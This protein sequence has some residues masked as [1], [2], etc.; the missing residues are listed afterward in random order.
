MVSCV[1]GTPVSHQRACR[2][3]RGRG[4]D[5]SY[6]RALA[7]DAAPPPPD[8]P[9]SPLPSSSRDTTWLSAVLIVAAI[10]GAFGSALRTPFQYDD[11]STVVENVSIR[12]LSAI[13][14]VL[15]PVADVSPTAGRPVLN[16]SFAVDYAIA[17]LDVLAYHATNGALHVLCALLLY[18]VVRSTLRLPAAASLGR[19][20]DVI[21]VLVAAIWAVH[22]L[23][24]GAVTYISGRS[25]VLVGLWF[26]ATLYA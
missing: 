19:H 11:L 21:A 15:S 1:G 26:M 24:S 16:V 4:S 22:P 10:A 9:V 6:D 17:G 14:T 2:C 20:R 23:Q 25:D 7:P 5:T 8:V 3:L 12:D 18:A 13:G